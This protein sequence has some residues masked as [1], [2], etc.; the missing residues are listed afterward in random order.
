MYRILEREDLTDTIHV[1]K[2]DAPAVAKRAKPGQFVILR[3]AED[4]ERIPLTIADFDRKAGTITVVFMEVGKTTMQMAKL[5]V[6][7]SLANF[8]GPLGLPT[9]VEKFGRVVVVGGGFGVATTYPIARAM[10]EAG[11]EVITIMGARTKDLLIWEDM[12]RSAS[13]ELIVCTD[14]GSYG[15]KGLV[16]APLKEML[17]DDCRI[18]RVVAIG[19]AIMMKFV[20]L[21]SQPF[22]VPTVVSLNPLMVDGT[23]LCGACRVSVDGVTKFACVDGPDF[24][25]H[26]VDWDLLLARQKIFVEEEKISLEHWRHHESCECS[27]AKA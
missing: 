12:M 13:H 14:D 26:K 15:R 18:D 21:T 3:V 22:G 16:T 4:G 23:G 20:A 17:E 2:I 25:G 11:N 9:E 6:G 5:G 8:A 7:D 10:K 1:F 24:D 27:K 19:P